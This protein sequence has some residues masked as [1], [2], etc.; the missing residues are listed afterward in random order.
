M[1]RKQIDQMIKASELQLANA[2]RNLRQ[3][4]E[5]DEARGQEIKWS[6]MLIGHK[7][8]LDILKNLKADDE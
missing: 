4:L 2:R 6:K 5:N 7:D 8:L 1:T 3:I